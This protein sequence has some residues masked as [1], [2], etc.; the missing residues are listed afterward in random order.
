MTDILLE[1]IRALV[2]GG[3]LG[4]LVYVGK[5]R[6]PSS[7]Q[8]WSWIIGGF[9]LLLFVS[10]M[11][12]TVIFATLSRFVLVGDTETQAFLEKSIGFLGGFIV[13][14]IGLLKWIPK[15]LNEREHV[16]NELAEVS[17]GDG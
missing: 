4:F 5:T 1:S 13:L 17:N 7:S 14:A 12:F 10:V 3:L 11:D 6:L 9:S 2:L 15:E 16:E 8:G